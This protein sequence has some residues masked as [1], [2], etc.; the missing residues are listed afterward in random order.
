MKISKRCVVPT[1][2]LRA[3]LIVEK[4][5]RKKENKKVKIGHGVENEEQVNTLA[6]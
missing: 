3:S 5:K 1:C 6:L 4:E 2:R